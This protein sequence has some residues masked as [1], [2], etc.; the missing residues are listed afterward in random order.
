L[1]IVR[2][3]QATYIS[4]S[5]KDVMV[6]TPFS[7]L[8]NH[9]SVQLWIKECIRIHHPLIHPSAPLCSASNISLQ[10]ELN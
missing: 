10:E 7:Y 8:E 4:A 9:L 3:Y 5:I 6:N 2:S 1:W